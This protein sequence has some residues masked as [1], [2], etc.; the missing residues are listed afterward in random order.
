[1]SFQK[2]HPVPA[3]AHLGIFF[4]YM[5]TQVFSPGALAVL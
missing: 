4:R 5:S 3:R 1:M 2:I